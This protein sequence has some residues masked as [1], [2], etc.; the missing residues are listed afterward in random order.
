MCSYMIMH[1]HM[2]AF[3]YRYMVLIWILLLWHFAH[4]CFQK[5]TTQELK[6]RNAIKARPMDRWWMDRWMKHACI[7]MKHAC[8]SNGILLSLGRTEVNKVWCLMSV[9]PALGRLR[10][11]D[12]FECETSLVYISR[13]CFEGWGN[14][15]S[16]AAKRCCDQSNYCKRKHLTGHLLMVS[17]G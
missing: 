16:V 6:G 12:C 11:K 1:F 17:E 7:S 3:T 13:S 14:W 8:V 2:H 15:C 9:I 4:G 10:Q 5:N